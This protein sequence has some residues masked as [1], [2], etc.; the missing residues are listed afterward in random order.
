MEQLLP[1]IRSLADESRLRILDL[2]LDGD[3]TVSELSA[4]LNLPQPRV[5][6]HLTILREEGIVTIEQVGRQRTYRVDAERIRPVVDA[7][8]SAQQ[9]ERATPPRSAQAERLVRND[10]PIRQARTCYDHLAGVV[11]VQLMDG[12]LARDWLVADSDDGKRLHYRLTDSGRHALIAR[13]VDVVGAEASRRLH[14]FGCTDWTERRHHLGGA[15]G[16]AVLSA[17]VDAGVAT[18]T[19]GTRVVAI[20]GSLSEWLA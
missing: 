14:A 13:G 9:A 11:G 15:L 12:M 19:P 20:T 6:T 4:R 7:L 1:L 3:A 10:V 16:A 8:Q 2:L 18:R 17:L 5:S